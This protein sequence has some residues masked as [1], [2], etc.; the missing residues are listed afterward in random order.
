MDEGVARLASVFHAHVSQVADVKT[1][2]LGLDFGEIQP[3]YSLVTN[4][5]PKPLKK[6]EYTVCRQLTLGETDTHLTFTI[7]EGNPKDGTHNH[8]SSGTHGGHLGGTG[9]HVHTQE[10]SHVHDV[11][12]PEKMRWLK[13]G[14]RVLVAWVGKEGKEAVVIDIVLPAT[15]LGGS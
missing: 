5:F 1:G 6:E 7:P 2:S 9:A 14:D 11:L 10:G 8:G 13:P 3:D 15:V 4:S 12:I